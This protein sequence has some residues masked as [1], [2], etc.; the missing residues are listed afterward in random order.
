M[1][2][3]GE[4]APPAPFSLL[5]PA[6]D[7]QVSNLDPVTFTWEA[8][9]DDNVV[10][11]L[12]LSPDIGSDRQF[13][14]TESRWVQPDL[15]EGR[16]RWAVTAD[17]G[18]SVRTSLGAGSFEVVSEVAAD[19]LPQQARTRLSVWPNPV[20]STMQVAYGLD[21]PGAV[22]LDVYDLL[23]RRVEGATLG[24]QGPGTHEAALNMARH[25]AG[26]YVVRLTREGQ[27]PQFARFVLSD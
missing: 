27:A 10:Y 3:L 26:S 24:W 7:A 2:G 16:Y 23:G 15:A 19:P 4:D 18:H 6:D 8:S 9:T 12:Y 20:Q 14:T 5:A 1:E 22:A 21:A 13:E 17:D 25:P 11:T